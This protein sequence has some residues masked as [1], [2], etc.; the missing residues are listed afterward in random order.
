MRLRKKKWITEAIKEYTDIVVLPDDDLN[1]YKGKWQQIFEN[2]KPI[3]VEVGTGKGL[4]I[5]DSAQQTPDINYI[6]IEKEDT[7]LYYAV[8]KVVNQ[9]LA[10]VRLINGDVQLLEEIFAVGEIARIYINFCDPWPKVRHAKRRLTHKNFLVKYQQILKPG[11]QIHFK[12]DNEALFEFS[13]NEFAEFGLRLK[14]I[15][16]DLHHSQYVGNIM[17]EYERKFSEQGM[18]IY[19]CEASFN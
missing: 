11:G 6:G 14:N 5:T 10:N 17:T 13:L 2:N 1:G 4:F 16:F 15:T 9:K 12:T 18:R 8:Q 7:V 3:Y 19:R